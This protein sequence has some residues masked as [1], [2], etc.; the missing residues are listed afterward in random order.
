[1]IGKA[2]LALFLVTLLLSALPLAHAHGDQD[3]DDIENER[4][5]SQCG[6][7]SKL[8]YR[9]YEGSCNNLFFPNSGK[10]GIFYSRGAEGAEFADGV[11][12]PVSNRPNE[13]VISNAISRDD[14]NQNDAIP[15]SLFSTQFGQFVNHDLDN[16]RLINSS[17]LSFANEIS[18]PE[19]DDDLCWIFANPRAGN[20][21]LINGCLPPLNGVPKIRTKF[22]AGDIVNGVFQVYN[23]ATSWLDLSQIYGPSDSWNSIIRTHQNGLLS[24]TDYFYTVNP[25]TYPFFGVNPIN[26]TLINGPPSFAATQAPV[27]PLLFI[28][29]QRANPNIIFTSGDERVGENA[30]LSMFHTLFI[31]EHNRIATALKAQF[32]D[33]SDELLFQEARRVNIAQYQ[34]VVLYEY[35]PNEFGQY[36]FDKLVG[37]YRGYDVDSP[38]AIPLVFASAA[39]R[40]GHSSFRNYV[41]IDTCGAPT[42]LNQPANG[43]KLFAGGQVGGPVLPLDAAG[44]AGSYENLLRGLITAHTLPNDVLINNVLRS[45]PF[46]T[47]V[48]GGT[49]VFAIDLSR[50]RLNGVPN[51]NTLRKAYFN[52]GRGRSAN[53]YGSSGCPANLESKPNQQDPLAC[54]QVLVPNNATLATS[55][56]QLYGKVNRIDALVGLLIEPHVAGTSFGPSL[57]NIIVQTY[58]NAR[59]NDRF[60]F[61]NRHQIHAF[62]RAQIAAIKST[63]LADLFVRNFDMPANKMPANPFLVSQFSC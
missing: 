35:V 58:A 40:Y 60:W 30:A 17:D 26:F 4:F 27:D 36:F 54:F 59:D 25:N 22:S 52:N 39:F 42:L 45:L 61:E 6:T 18:V 49:D 43:Q 46:R 10:A 13:R 34:A 38:H 5:A 7:L 31:R 9:T 8:L 11:S 32:P 28:N 63:K 3:D 37:D 19:L 55:L 47:P 50:A 62:S 44:Q 1:M 41:P 20:L 14:P 57:G 51:Y 53:I 48:P 15:H 56:Q 16:N 2:H 29:P 12:Q 33:W 23:N 21:T 24:T